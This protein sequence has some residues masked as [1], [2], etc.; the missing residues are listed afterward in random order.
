MRTVILYIAVSLDGYIADKNGGVAWLEGADA[1]DSYETFVKGVDTVIM[2]W[3]TYE[4]VAA[5]LSPGG[6]PYAGLESYVLTHRKPPA[7]PGITFT[8]ESPRALV[9]RLRRTEG[10]GIWLCGGANLAQQFIAEGLV[11]IYHL[12]LIPVVLGGGMR[13]FGELAGIR[14]LRLLRTRAYNGVVEV[15]YGKQDGAGFTGNS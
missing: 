4:Q 1:G 3:N 13:L 10:K 9:G 6:W 12:S 15:I 7:V 11:D 14:A 2:G 5:E 8:E